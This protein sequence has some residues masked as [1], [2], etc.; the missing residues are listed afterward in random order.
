[1][2]K[3]VGLSILF[4]CSP[5]VFA[6]VDIVDAQ[7]GTM[8]WTN[9][10]TNATSVFTVEWAAD[11]TSGVWRSD[12]QGLSDLATTDRV[13]TVAVPTYFR[14]RGYSF[15]LV[16]NI[17]DLTAMYIAAVRDASNTTPGK[18]SKNLNP[19]VDFNP[20]L[21]WRT[22]DVGV[23]QIKV[24][25][26]MTSSSAS[27]YYA[28]H[29]N[30]VGGE[31][32]VTLCPDLYDFCRAYQGPQPL[33]RIKQVLGMPPWSR[34]DT[35]VEFWVDPN[36]L[37]RPSPDPETHDSEACLNFYSNA[38]SYMQTLAVNPAYVHWYTNTYATRYYDLPGGNPS[39]SWPWTRLGYTYDWGQPS[40]HVGLSEY[41]V[42][43]KWLWPWPETNK[44]VAME[45]YSITNA[46]LYGR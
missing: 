28:G 40:N 15:P 3:T 22:N 35:I 44:N 14:V 38:I 27:N 17:D 34:N 24:A 41:V 11:L 39:N 42:P 1:M 10:A 16:T 19:V 23:R 30:I 18:I 46:A 36:Y 9:D 6:E 29:T 12:W 8:T 7:P 31:Q 25:S 26:F 32:W 21:I 37:F 13:T 5:A 2:K 33:L 43:D 45:I 20:R 4:L